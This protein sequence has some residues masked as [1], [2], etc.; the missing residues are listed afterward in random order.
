MDSNFLYSQILGIHSPWQVSNV[1]LDL[2]SQKVEVFVDYTGVSPACSCGSITHFHGHNKVRQWRH[3]DTCQLTTLIVCSLPRTKCPQCGKTE[4]I[5]GSWSLPNSRFTL[6]FENVVISWLLAC[7]NQSAV[8]KRLN[9]TFSEVNGI[10]N[11]AVSRGLDQRK[12]EGI[13]QLSIDEKSMKKGHHYLTVLC[14]PKAGHVINVC[15]HRKSENVIDLIQQELTVE[16]RQEVEAVSMDMCDSFIV[17]TTA[18]LENADIVH[19]R[20]HISKMLNGAVDKVRRQE[21]S[22]LSKDNKSN[23]L[24][25][26]KYLWL[27]NFEKIL[28][29]RKVRFAQA[30]EASEKTAEVWVYK[31]AF[32]SFF[33]CKNEEDAK[34]FLNN[35]IK[36]AEAHQQSALNHV[37]GTFMKYYEGII[38]Y[39]KHPITNAFA[40]SMNGKIQELKTRARGF[41]AFENYR[42]NILFYFGGLNLA[43]TIS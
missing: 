22:R 10:M 6:L 43:H 33:D 18:T 3:L 39:V 11:R 21:V 42:K 28:P 4:T 1:N 20:F 25:K 34:D 9:L 8:A 31:E 35:W 24:K 32:R 37:A 16:Q 41:R 2:N 14:D 38:N 17:A 40:E 5:N 29:K 19:D 23:G 26:S 15:E 27:T 36:E 7:K 13:K 12:L 30:V